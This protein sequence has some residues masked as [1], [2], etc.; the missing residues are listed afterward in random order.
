MNL[1]QGYSVLLQG[2]SVFV[3]RFFALL[4]LK[5]EKVEKVE[6]IELLK[7]IYCFFIILLQTKW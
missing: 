3:T 5:V 6:K 7:H 4:F 2:Y 1:L